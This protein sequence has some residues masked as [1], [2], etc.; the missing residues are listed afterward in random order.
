VIALDFD[1]WLIVVAVA[2]VWVLALAA[3]LGLVYTGGHR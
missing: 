2:V 3:F 1:P